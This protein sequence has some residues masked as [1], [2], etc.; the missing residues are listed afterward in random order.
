MEDVCFGTL[1]EVKLSSLFI[2]GMGLRLY[3]DEKI[4]FDDELNCDCIDLVILHL[5]YITQD[6]MG[7]L[8]YFNGYHETTIDIITILNIEREYCY[9]L[10]QKLKRLIS[11]EKPS[12]K[13]TVLSEDVI[14]V[15]EKVIYI[16]DKK[17]NM[18][19]LLLNVLKYDIKNR[20]NLCDIPKVVN[21][22][23]RI[24]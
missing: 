6:S 3:K 11:L 14:S 10:I 23:R 2:D 7:L 21:L 9:L 1:F 19:Y 12:S 8:F 18:K 20:S 22:L 15:Y 13:D 5:Y 4:K 16:L 17:H 24:P